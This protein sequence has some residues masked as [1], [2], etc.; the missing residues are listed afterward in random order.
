MA[1]LAGC[2]FSIGI[3][4]NTPADA[5]PDTAID[6]AIDVAI[7]SSSCPPFYRVIGT[8][9]YAVL[10]PTNFKNH[11]TACA[12]HG[13]HL[14]IIDGKQELDDLV[15][16]GRTV[17]GVN[18]NSRFYV[19]LVQAPLQAE[20]EDS[21]VDFAD[22]DDNPDLWAQ[23]GANEPNDGADQNEGNHQEQVAALQLDRD[24]LVDLAHT[25]NVR[26]YCECDGISVGLMAKM[27]VDALP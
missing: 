5:P 11:V 17:M 8:G 2:G 20:P 3:G 10:D 13:T 4:D 27:Y 23:S 1:M 25:E 19:G 16:Y 18:N 6:A 9:V 12:S 7:D 22:R 21:W 15:V 26:A 14:A 24:G